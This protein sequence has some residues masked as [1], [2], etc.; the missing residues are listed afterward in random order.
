MQ[1][2]GPHKPH[3]THAQHHARDT[4]TETEHGGHARRQLVGD[5][6]VLGDVA[7]H[8]AL[9]D[10]VV[11]QADALVDGEPVADEEH[12]VLEHGLEVRV[13]RD[14]DGDVDADADAGPEEARDALGPAREDL[15]G[16]G[17][18]V[19]VGGVW[20]VRGLVRVGIVCFC[21][22]RGCVGSLLAMMVRAR[23]TRQNLPKAP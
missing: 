13:A 2:N 21:V 8:A 23:T 4:D 12:E 22:G 10:E 15:D 18:G 5:V 6:V 7:A 9:E 1:R 19:D 11:G 3:L 14:G 16:E 20:E 17:D